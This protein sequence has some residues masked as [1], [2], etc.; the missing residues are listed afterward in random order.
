MDVSCFS[1]NGRITALYWR[2]DMNAKPQLILTPTSLPTGLAR[3][4]WEE[5]RRMTAAELIKLMGAAHV[6]HP[7]FTAKPRSLIP[8]EN[9]AGRRLVFERVDVG[10]WQSTKDFLRWAAR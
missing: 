7:E 9:L 5:R 1:N 2:R 6:N 4:T 10:F 8:L 3:T